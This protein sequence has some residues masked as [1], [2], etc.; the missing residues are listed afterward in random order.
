MPQNIGFDLSGVGGSLLRRTWML[1]RTYNW[2]LIMPHNFS[3]NIGFLVSQYCQDVR[4]GDY[5]MSELSK[6]RYGPYQRTYP[7]LQDIDVV[8]LTFLVPID[9]SV[10]NYFYAWNEL[11][12]DANGFYHPKN[13]YKRTIFVI[14]Y[15]RTNVQS[16]KFVLEGV[17]PRMKPRVAMSY[18]SEGIVTLTM[19]LSV[20][21]IRS[22][23][24][25]G[26][27]REGVTNLLGD[28]GS[29]A[30]NIL[31]RMGTPAVKDVSWAGGNTV[32]GFGGTTPAGSLFA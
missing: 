28:I 20:D 30:K 10:Y 11:I 21:N 6:M 18:A 4:F 32:P 15:D 1:Q 29:K 19:E 24:F 26:S 17:F 14:M 2:Q 7:G 12:V 31:G 3:G 5:S 13:E 22:E 23:S 9:N 8:S 25:I 16:T 27:I